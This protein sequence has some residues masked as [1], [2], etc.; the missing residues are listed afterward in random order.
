ME[1]NEHLAK[2]K[3]CAEYTMIC[4]HYL[5]WGIVLEISNGIANNQTQRIAGRIPTTMSRKTGI[6]Q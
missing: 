2:M 5:V 3:N 4:I 6:Q 1:K